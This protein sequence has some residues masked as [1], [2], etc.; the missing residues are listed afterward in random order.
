MDANSESRSASLDPASLA[1]IA[2]R[3]DSVCREMTNTLLRSGRSAVLNMA[4]DFSCSLVTADNQLLASA[5]G[6]P[7]HVFGS[8]FLTEAMSTLHPD[9][10]E[11]D[12]FLHNDVYL[13]NTHSADHT[14]LVPVFADGEHM[15][16]CCAKAH[17]ADCGNSLPTTYMPFAGDVYEEGALNFPCIRIQQ[18]FRDLE[19]I[20]RMCRRRIRVPDQWYGD[21]LAMLGAA[22]IGER[23]LKELVAKFGK[24]AIRQFV[25]EWFDYSERRMIHALKQLPSA[26]LV[27]TGAHDPF[28][29]VPDGVPLKVK[30]KI[31]A[32]EGS[33]E[34]DLRDNIDCV[35]CGLNESRTCAI[36]NVVTG[37]FNSVDPGVPHNAGSFRRITVH[38]RENCVVG[39][40]LFPTSCSVATTNIGDRLVN[41]T[42]AAFAQLGE[43]YGLAEGGVGMGPAYGVIS[44]RD[45]RRQGAPYVNQVFIGA[46]G[47][48]AAPHN[49]GWI[50]YGLPVVAGLMYRDSIEIDEQKYPIIYRD[51][52]LLTDTGGAGRFRG[53]P[54]ARVVYGPRRDP[55]MVVYPLDGHHYPPK[56]VLGGQSGQASYAAKLDR[57]GE[58]RSLPAVSAEQIQPG[59]YVVGVDTGGGGY[60]SPLDRDA[61][62]VRADVLEGFVSLE[63]ARQVYGVVFT[64]NAEDESLAVDRAA[65]AKWRDTLRIQ[66]TD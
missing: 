48:P 7:V 10:A 57:E 31:D 60:G 1:V 42:Q 50:N 51:V 59:E 38:L 22:R 9:F 19:D 3:F 43:G 62:M 25:R 8:Q 17:Q 20:I 23:R 16:T 53:A 6:L 4:R 52:R 64:G 47:G 41:I 49:D 34:I 15:F 2:N 5:E 12:A 18:A 40:P 27:G 21:Y 35:P 37:I 45:F 65:T 39:I 46:N 63:K 32:I 36:N 61:E 14:I 66:N 33:V 30:V 26:D 28:P 24:P 44:G 13:G 11:G 55:M 56:G 54:G 58:E 29:A